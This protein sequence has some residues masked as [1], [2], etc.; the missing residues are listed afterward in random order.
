MNKILIIVLL[1]FLIS[2]PPIYGQWEALDQGIAYQ[3]INSGGVYKMLM[4]QN[5]LLVT[6]LYL[7]DG[8]DINY[9]GFAHF[10]FQTNSWEHI[11]DSIYPNC[12]SFEFYNNKLTVS[13][14]FELGMTPQIDGTIFTFDNDQ[15]NWLE[16]SPPSTI[17]R[18][19]EINNNLYMLGSFDE[20]GDQPSSGIAAYD[21]ESFESIYDS[22]SQNNR[23][24]DIIEWNDELYIVGKSLGSSNHT[25]TGLAKLNGNTFETVH[26]DFTA[27]NHTWVYSLAVYDN[28]LFIGGN[29]NHGTGHTGNGIQYF[30]GEEMHEV[31]G[32]VSGFVRDMMVY[33]GELYVV[34]GF[35][36]LGEGSEPGQETGEFCSSVAKWNGE[37]WTC[38]FDGEFSVLE[39]SG[40]RTLEIYDDT[41]YIGGN[42]ASMDGDTAKSCIARRAITP[43]G[44]LSRL[45]DFTVYPN[46]SS[47]MIQL[48]FED[49]LETR[50]EVS[51]YN[52]IG[53]LVYSELLLAWEYRYSLSTET[54]ASGVYLVRIKLGSAIRTK[55]VVVK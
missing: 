44:G 2:E 24:D 55:R 46:P 27:P 34:G 8:Y 19:R 6:G 33:K 41:L 51:L 36:H 18:M 47:G 3:G 4:N 49:R 15:W 16:E 14:F 13:G 22:I 7:E 12:Y 28:K 52:S 26:S 35:Y 43:D 38:L 29:F 45:D 39:N 31:G 53:Q 11:F 17:F 9:N 20:V 25:Y 48:Q 5:K 30:D 37:E 32:G 23:L 50:A 40:V 21:G 42:W 1:S 54:M 10:N